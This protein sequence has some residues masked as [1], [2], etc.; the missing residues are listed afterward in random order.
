MY[1]YMRSKNRDKRE[2]I[3]LRVER[4]G[5]EASFAHTFSQHKHTSHVTAPGGAGWRGGHTHAL[6]NNERG[7]KE[8]IGR[9]SAWQ[10]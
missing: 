10:E 5:E 9:G 1:I 7:N 4:G 2:Y 3:K 6:E 8:V